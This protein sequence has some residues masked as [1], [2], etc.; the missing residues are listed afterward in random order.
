MLVGVGGRVNFGGEGTD[1]TSTIYIYPF[2][3]QRA[4]LAPEVEY[5]VELRATLWF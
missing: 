2:S 5:A 4:F 3:V 1:R